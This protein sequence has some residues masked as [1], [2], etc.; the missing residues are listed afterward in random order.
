MIYNISP[1]KHPG[2]YLKEGTYSRG[3]LITFSFKRTREWS[4]GSWEVYGITVSAGN[5]V[6]IERRDNAHKGTLQ[7][8]TWIQ[9]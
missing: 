1:N 3:A 6:K 9:K 5:R 2:A 4:S 8:S 7:A